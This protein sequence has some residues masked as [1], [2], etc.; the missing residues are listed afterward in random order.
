MG[1]LIDSDVI[2]D[3]LNKK[4]DFLSFIITK[5]KSN[6]FI[7]VITWAEILYGIKRSYNPDKNLAHFNGFVKEL[8][9]KTVEF[10][11]TVADTFVDLKIELEKKGAKLEDFDL[12]IGST[13]LTKNLTLATK[14]IKHFSK[15]PGLKLHPQPS[16]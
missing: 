9:I 1:L 6:L 16:N 4:S 10:N 2:I 11:Q 7:S 15:I 12:I 3:H 8:N 5:S 13:A 14:N